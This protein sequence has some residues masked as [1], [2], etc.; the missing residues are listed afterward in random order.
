MRPYVLV[1]L[2][3]FSP[4]TLLAQDKPASQP[5]SKPA[6]RSTGG[7][8]V[9]IEKSYKGLCT[10]HVYK[11]EKANGHQKMKRYPL[12]ELV[13]NNKDQWAFLLSKIPAK[14]F[15]KKNPRPANNDPIRT[16]KTPDFKNYMVIAVFRNDTV[17]AK[18]QIKSVR[19]KD[20]VCHVTV[21]KATA[22]PEA[23]PGD[24]GCYTAVL[25]RKQTGTVK[26]HWEAQKP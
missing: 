26:F 22:P 5:S 2:A 25:V 13:V 8:L 1:L 14:A 19:F 21:F 18:P 12:K 10:P 24:G 23:M 3:V 7:A 11:L 4:A 6:S 15:S 16:A 20:G 17:S 9:K